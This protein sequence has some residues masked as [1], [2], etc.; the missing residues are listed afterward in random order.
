MKTH[1]NIGDKVLVSNGRSC[2]YGVI[3]GKHLFSYDVFHG[4]AI[5]DPDNDSVEEGC[6][7]K[8]YPKRRVFWTAQDELEKM[9]D[10]D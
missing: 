6:K 7:V 2:F 3:K 9:Y 1:I 5:Y 10:E 8:R 4:F